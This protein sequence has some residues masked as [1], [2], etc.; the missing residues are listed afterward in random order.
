MDPPG[1][2][3]AMKCLVEQ[4]G[5]T[6]KDLEDIIGTGSCVAEVLARKQSLS[7]GMIGRLH[8]RPALRGHRPPRLRHSLG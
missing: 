3:E 4:Q 1:P 5:M 2:V 6:R 7:T 8:D